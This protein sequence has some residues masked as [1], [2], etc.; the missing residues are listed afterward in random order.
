MESTVPDKFVEI[1][2]DTAD[3]VLGSET[4]SVEWDWSHKLVG[5]VSKEVQIPVKNKEHREF[6]FSTMK[7]ACV[8]YLKYWALIAPVNPLASQ[9]IN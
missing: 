6:L 8:D 5:K 1:V 2:N 3:K 9:K 7:S 4:A